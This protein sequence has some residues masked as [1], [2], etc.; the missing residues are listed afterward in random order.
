ML[1][2][3]CVVFKVFPRCGMWIG[4][5]TILTSKISSIYQLQKKDHAGQQ[6]NLD[7]YEKTIH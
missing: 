1:V 5:S 2:Q 3:P 4:F 7:Q 6:Q